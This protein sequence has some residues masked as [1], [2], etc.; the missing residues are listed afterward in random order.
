MLQ[1]AKLTHTAAEKCFA[2]RTHDSACVIDIADK[3]RLE[4][5]GGGSEHLYSPCGE[6]VVIGF[7]YRIT[8]FIVVPA[9]TYC[10]YRQWATTVKFYFC[11][12]GYGSQYGA[13]ALLRRRKR[14]TRDLQQGQNA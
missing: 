1:C 7:F 5:G 13:H 4:E 10:N 2:A 9:Q 12:S 8:F 6:R 14:I 3:M 11:E